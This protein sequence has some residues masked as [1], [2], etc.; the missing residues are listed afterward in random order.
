MPSWDKIVTE[1][2]S[3]GRS[4]AL[5][6]AQDG[7]VLKRRRTLE[8]LGGSSGPRT[9]CYHDPETGEEF[10]GLP[11]D[12]YSFM[13]YTMERGLRPGR[14]PADLR[15][16]FQPKGNAE[17]AFI[18]HLENPV[19]ASS[20]GIDNSLIERLLAKIDQLEA[21][22]DGRTEAGPVEVPVQGRLL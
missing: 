4:R 3:G 11:V 9:F 15:A 18:E 20:G 7:D 1:V 2:Q 22:L 12:A 10:P 17:M 5:A 16:K 8:P 14:A 13:H 21:R 19:G 6:A